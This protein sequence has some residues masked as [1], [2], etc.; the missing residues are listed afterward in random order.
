MPATV[1]DVI[2]AVVDPAWIGVAAELIATF[3]NTADPRERMNLLFSGLHRRLG[4]TDWTTCAAVHSRITALGHLDQSLPLG[5]LHPTGD[6]PN[7]DALRRAVATAPLQVE[8][9]HLAFD[10]VSFQRCFAMA[11]QAP[12]LPPESEPAPNSR[13]DRRLSKPE[14]AR[15]AKDLDTRVQ[16]LLLAG[17]DDMALFAAMADDMPRFKQLLDAA[18]PG[19]L[20][21]LSQRF[22]AFGHFAVLLTTIAAAIRDG[23]IT[24]PR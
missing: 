9:E 22:P 7:A 16:A 8:G 2:H 5:A 20:D 18:D 19:E 24:V 17:L 14:K 13:A 12:P 4:T 10:P 1:E 15:I 21:Q 3:P 6:N 11:R 23:A